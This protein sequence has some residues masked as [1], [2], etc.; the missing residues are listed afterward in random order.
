LIPEVRSGLL[1]L[2]ERAKNFPAVS[3]VLTSDFPAIGV[4]LTM[5]RLM[6]AKMDRRIGK[7][8]EMRLVKNHLKKVK[9]KEVRSLAGVIYLH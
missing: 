1:V 3:T 8:I 5:S 6:A 9:K 7:C 2:G 4:E